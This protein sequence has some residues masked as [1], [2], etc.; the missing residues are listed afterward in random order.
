MWMCWREFAG[1]GGEDGVLGVGKRI[2]GGNIFVEIVMGG[3]ELGRFRARRKC[4]YCLLAGFE[5]SPGGIGQP[6]EIW[7]MREGRVEFV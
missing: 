3:G 6:K 5:D 7:R 1:A 4:Q 2:W